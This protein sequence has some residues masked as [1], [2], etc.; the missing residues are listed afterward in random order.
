MASSSVGSSRRVVQVLP[1]STSRINTAT[2]QPEGNLHLG[3]PCDCVVVLRMSLHWPR[4]A[5]S[6]P[7]P[8][9]SP[10]PEKFRTPDSPHAHYCPP[11]PSCRWRG[12]H[13]AAL[14]H[15]RCY[16]VCAGFA[17]FKRRSSQQL[18]RKS[19]GH[20]SVPSVL[21]PSTGSKLPTA[22]SSHSHPLCSCRFVVL[23]ALD[24]E[25]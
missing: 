24:V 16:V 12:N 6:L 8:P 10:P 18:H 22:S 20:R 17:S 4:R 13:D 1:A 7:S 21:L 9:A 3:K 2:Y 14:G 11:S 5:R 23:C 19:S 15:L 25:T